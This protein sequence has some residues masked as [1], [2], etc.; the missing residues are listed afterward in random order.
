MLAD[1]RT[2]RARVR[3][4]ATIGLMLFSACPGTVAIKE[5]L[6]DPA[7]FDGKTV[8][9]AGVTKEA[10]GAFAFGVYQ[11]DDGTGLLTVVNEGAG[12]TP[13][14][15]AKVGVEGTFQSVFTLGTLNGAVLREKRR[16]SP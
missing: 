2:H 15:G 8:R 1:L 12:S 10:A 6:D 13:Q 3:L 16:R 4:V 5:L 14:V 7:R 9:I 11:V